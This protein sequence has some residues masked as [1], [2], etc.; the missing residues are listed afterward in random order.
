M[1]F[2][3]EYLEYLENLVRI[4][5]KA[6]SLFMKFGL[7]SVTMD[8]IAHSIGISKK[9]IYT[10]F[11][12]KDALVD[13]VIMDE[14][15]FNKKCCNE[16]RVHAKNAIHEIFLALQMMQKT[17]SGMNPMLL[18]ELNKYYNKS[19][20]KFEKFKNEYLYD[21]IKSNLE[22]G[23]QEKLYRPTINI[24]IISWMR[25]ETMMMVFAS[26]FATKQKLDVLFL[27]EQLMEHF[28]YG[29]VTPKGYRLITKY[30][31]ERN[32]KI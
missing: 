6:H 14:I 13:D 9:T 27:E 19:F 32:I 1:L 24:E 18:F 4:K 8:D 16:D 31:H 29:V 23:I 17:M 7:R 20:Q 12:D 10:Y 22:R 3:S 5:E 15:T 21:I 28:L 25:L 30:Q 26:E 11:E 2:K